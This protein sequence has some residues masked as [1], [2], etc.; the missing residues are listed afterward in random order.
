MKK[1]KLKTYRIHRLVAENFIENPNNY[2]VINHKDGNKTNN[3][4]ENLEWCTISHNTQHAINTG[5]LINKPQVFK[6]VDRCVYESGHHI[7]YNYVITKEGK[8]YNKIKNIEL[9]SWIHSSLEHMICLY[10]NGKKR[11]IQ[12]KNLM[13]ECFIEGY[14]KGDIIIHIDNNKSN[15]RL[16]NLRIS[17]IRECMMKKDTNNKYKNIWSV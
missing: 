17:S 4:V 14:K 1:Q 5:L 12:V 10:E 3:N 9:K 16:D 7:N 11:Q 15:N 2:K 13:A 8:I 6:S